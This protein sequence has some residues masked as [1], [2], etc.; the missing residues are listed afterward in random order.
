MFISKKILFYCFITIVMSQSLTAQSFISI[1]IDDVPN[2]FFYDYTLEKPALLH[3]LDSLQIPVSIFINEKNVYA[4]GDS[5]KN[6]TWLKKW[7]NRSYIT[8]GNHSYSHFHYSEVGFEPFSQDV[9][10][11]QLLTM[12]FN[13]EKKPL[14]LFRFPY[15]DLGNDSLEHA[16][17]RE[18][19]TEH[20]Y[21]I[22]PFTIESSDWLF[23]S[24]YERYLELGDHKNAHRI[25]L[26]YVSFT[27]KQVDFFEN[28]TLEVY[29]RP[30]KHI[31]LCHDS[32]LN[33]KYLPLLL[34]ELKQKEYSFTSIEDA[35]SD[36]I[37]QSEN[38]YF[39]KYGVSWLYRWIEDAKLRM[40]YMR[41]EPSLDHIEAEL[42]ALNK[43]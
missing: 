34:I 25:G 40:S 29:K 4:N 24:L 36:P 17:I 18:F 7:V 8:L 21:T 5:L 41:K 1:S 13:T 2:T 42:N 11:G 27:M 32:K 12:E 22:A 43:N 30:I 15:N 39:K 20:N 26:E 38:F 10:K 37:Y 9:L 31:Y 23:N 6:Y 3:T 16:K 19:L 33:A 28:L 35:L 14:T